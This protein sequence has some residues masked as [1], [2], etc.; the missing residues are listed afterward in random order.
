MGG[1]ASERQTSMTS[2]RRIHNLKGIADT[3]PDKSKVRVLF[4]CLGNICRSTAAQGVLESLAQQQG[5]SVEVDSAGTYGGHAGQGADPR[6]KVHARRRGYELTHRARRVRE[7]D[8]SDF[9]III[10]MDD[11]N[12]SDFD[13]WRLPLRMR[14]RFSV[15]PD[16]CVSIPVGTMCLTR[17]MK[18]PK[19]SSWC[20]TCLKMP[21]NV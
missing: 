20:S 5:V 14:P 6:M 19:A 8:F 11:A 21:V 16:S 3:L 4:V 10:G 18:A 13:G 15:W 2:R 9:D 17:I 1:L 7:S 12:I